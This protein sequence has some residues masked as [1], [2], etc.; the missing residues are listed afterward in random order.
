[1]P[2]DY[3]IWLAHYTEHTNYEG[4]YKMWQICSNGKI[5]GILGP[6]DIDIWYK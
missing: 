4:K 3:N 6:V 5:D 1:M 2:T